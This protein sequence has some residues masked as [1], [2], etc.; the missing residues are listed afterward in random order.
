MTSYNPGSE[1]VA[2]LLPQ[3]SVGVEIG[4]Y[5]GVSSARFLPKCKLLHLV[6]PWSLGAYPD[7]ADF[8]TKYAHHIGGNTED[9]AQRYFDAQHDSVARKFRGMPVKIHRMT[10]AQFFAT[11]IGEVDWVYI[12]GLHDYDS[13]C[14]DLQGAFGIVK[15]GGVIYG[16]DY[17]NKP[18]VARAVEEIA[19][20]RELLGL[21]QYR[22]QC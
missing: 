13:V 4:V 14:A 22:I 1:I 5:Q 3:R 8:L 19:P 21:K 17:G 15:K 2:S 11:F 12:D 7:K 20:Y 6:D 9:A 18:G 10:S 16:D